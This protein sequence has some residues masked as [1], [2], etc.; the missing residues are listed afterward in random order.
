MEGNLALLKFN[1]CLWRTLIEKKNNL[2]KFRNP[3]KKTKH[4]TNN[5]KTQAQQF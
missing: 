5:K 2:K 4:K 3:K 1:D